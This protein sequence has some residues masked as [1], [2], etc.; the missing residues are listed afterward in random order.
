[1][2][3]IANTS[4]EASTDIAATLLEADKSAHAEFKLP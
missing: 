2:S 3:K 4:A 1:L